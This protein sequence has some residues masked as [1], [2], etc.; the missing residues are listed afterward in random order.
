MHIEGR[1][2]SAK[3]NAEAGDLQKANADLRRRHSH[4]QHELKRKD[5]EYE[6]L[7][8]ALYHTSFQPTKL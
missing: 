4:F 1:S 3:M 8:V 2:D 6:K 7:Q 5:L